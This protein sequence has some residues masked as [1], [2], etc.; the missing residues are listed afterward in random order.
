M[1][2]NLLPWQIQHQQLLACRRRQWLGAVGICFVLTL[3]WAALAWQE[4]A[5]EER[6]AEEFRRESRFVTYLN[7]QVDVLRRRNRTLAHREALFVKLESPIRP[8]GLLGLLGQIAQSCQGVVVERLESVE[9]AE[10]NKKPAPGQAQTAVLVS[11]QLQ[12]PSSLPV[13]QFVLGLRDRELFRSVE[14]KN[15]GKFAAASTALVSYVVECW[16]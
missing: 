9:R 13:A 16:F 4:R 12:A 1:T 3:I 6:A 11:I 7:E 15:G 14:L 2:C 10:P 8:L 5:V